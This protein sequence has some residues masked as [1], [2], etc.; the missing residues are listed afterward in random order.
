MTP[1]TLSSHLLSSSHFSPSSP[2]DVC[3]PFPAATAAPE[4]EVE[5][6]AAAAMVEATKYLV[7][8]DAQLSRISP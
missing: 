8:L 1:R 5:V 6:E 2:L 3:S 4:E 7:C